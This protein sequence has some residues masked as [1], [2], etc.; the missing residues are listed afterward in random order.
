MGGPEDSLEEKL[1]LCAGLEY[2]E[3][4]KSESR[5]IRLFRGL[6]PDVRE[7]LLS[8]ID[9]LQKERQRAAKPD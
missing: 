4:N 6:P 3:L 7:Y 2:A 1:A 5:L 9:F 8:F